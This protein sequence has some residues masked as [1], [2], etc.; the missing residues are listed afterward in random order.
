MSSLE[1]LDDMIPV[2]SN[3]EWK[4]SV[5]VKLNSP[6]YGTKQQNK[7][8]IKLM[9]R[10]GNPSVDYMFTN[11]KLASLFHV[12]FKDAGLAAWFKLHKIIK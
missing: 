1:L 8:L 5:M 4:Y 12:R 9:E 3:D 10:F 7:E 6:Y 2:T 11:A